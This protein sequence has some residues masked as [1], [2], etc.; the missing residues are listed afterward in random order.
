MHSSKHEIY[1]F[2]RKFNFEEL[3]C[4]PHLPRCPQMSF[5]VS[6]RKRPANVDLPKYLA[7]IW[8]HDAIKIGA[9]HRAP[10]TPSTDSLFDMFNFTSLVTVQRGARS[11]RLL[12][13]LFEM[14]IGS[15]Q[16]RTL[17]KS[18]TWC[19]RSVKISHFRSFLAVLSL[20]RSHS[21]FCNLHSICSDYSCSSKCKKEMGTKFTPT[22]GFQGP[23]VNP[24]SRPP[25]INLCRPSNIVHVAN[26]DSRCYLGQ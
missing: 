8:R 21:S 17:A 20:R 9:S 13:P 16:H 3:N 2:F 22:G 24:I 12:M 11:R 5:L 4:L 6:P 18:R 23:P 14:Q 15:L 10:I 1:F 26:E 25:H 19:R 7:T